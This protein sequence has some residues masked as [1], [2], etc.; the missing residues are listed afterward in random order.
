MKYIK[1]YKIFEDHANDVINK[2]KSELLPRMEDE[3]IEVTIS[4]NK[5]SLFLRGFSRVVGG[6]KIPDIS[7]GMNSP[8]NPQP[9]DL[10]YA[11]YVHYL[12]KLMEGAGY[13]ICDFRVGFKYSEIEVIDQGKACN[14]S[15]AQ[16]P[17]SWVEQAIIEQG[18]PLI[19]S[20]GINF[21]KK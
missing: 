15:A 12:I 11:Q 3:N 13:K 20:I 5:P 1:S 14:K 4:N 2:V 10:N 7:C 6:G 17:V 8:T 18:N 21:F 16:D 19:Y 9:F